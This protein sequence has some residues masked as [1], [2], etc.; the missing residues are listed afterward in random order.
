[1]LT[2]T[3]V[4]KRHGS[5][6]ALDDV[7]L[8]IEAGE[9][10]GLLGPN[11]AGKSTLMSLVA[12]L[13]T[14]DA[15]RI[16]LDGQPVSAINPASRAALGL[17]PQHIALYPK[18][19][20]EQNLRI[21]G[22]LYGLGGALLRERV[23]HGLEIR[24]LADRRRDPARTFSGGRQ[25]R[26][27]LVASLLHRPRLLLRVHLGRV[28]GVCRRANSPVKSPRWRP[29]SCTSPVAPCPGRTGQPGT[30]PVVQRDRVGVAAY[31]GDTWCH[32]C[33]R[34]DLRHLAFQPRENLRLMA[35]G[36]GR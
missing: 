7:S 29:C 16:I 25:R 36:I 23:D 21:F 35:I 32:D 34:H 1:M 26:L 15:G 24:Q 17:V 8:Q 27:N 14:P 28:P 13:H 6:T 9:F 11:R 10:F 5:I 19:S 33:R 20:A 4:T 12:G 18:L 3:H 22:Q 30:D 31:A 2:L